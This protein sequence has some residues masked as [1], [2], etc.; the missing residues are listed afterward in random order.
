MFVPTILCAFMGGGGSLRFVLCG[1]KKVKTAR[2]CSKQVVC[3]IVY[4]ERF[5]AGL[6]GS[7]R[8]AYGRR[9][10]KAGGRN[11]I[12]RFQCTHSNMFFVYADL[13]RFVS[14]FA[15]NA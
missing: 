7:Q 4:V 6:I 10:K 12:I 8:N 5:G 14:I 13:I 1:K 2:H 15:K 3:N 9:L 11:T